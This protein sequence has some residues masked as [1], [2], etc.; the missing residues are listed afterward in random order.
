MISPSEKAQF[1]ID[2]NEA[3][4]PKSDFHVICQAVIDMEK[5]IVS[6]LDPL[7]DSQEAHNK[8]RTAIGLDIIKY[9]T[10]EELEVCDFT[11]CY[12]CKDGKCSTYPISD[13]PE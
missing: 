6:H 12:A 13:C 2:R 8:L 4:D 5:A 9:A 11:D 7:S 10:K 1:Y 3:G